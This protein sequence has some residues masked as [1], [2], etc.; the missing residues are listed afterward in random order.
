VT[1]VILLASLAILGYCLYYLAVCAA[2]PF[3]H[4]RRCHAAGG[5][6]RSGRDCRRC[7]GTGRRVRLGRRAY[8]YLRDEYQRGNR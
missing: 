2:A 6:G 4:C 5:R 1:P 8:D 3:G 7:N